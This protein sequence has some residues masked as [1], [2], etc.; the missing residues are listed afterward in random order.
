[1]LKIWILGGIL[2]FGPVAV[3]AWALKHNADLALIAM[4]GMIATYFMVIYV[5]FEGLGFLAFLPIVSY[6]VF[7]EIILG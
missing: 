2:L 5:T 3:W 7:F 6:P 4:L 1:M